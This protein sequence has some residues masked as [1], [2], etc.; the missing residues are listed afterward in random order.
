MNRRDR[1]CIFKS[2]RALNSTLWRLGVEV[3]YS[4][5]VPGSLVP[6]AVVLVTPEVG[7]PTELR[8]GLADSIVFL[9]DKL[10]CGS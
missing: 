6:M 4:A 10:I 9:G 3:T 1:L 5:R 7:L 8:L 2:H